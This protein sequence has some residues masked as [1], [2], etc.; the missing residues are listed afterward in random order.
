MTWNRLLYIQRV[1]KLLVTRLNFNSRNK[2]GI[3]IAN[4]HHYFCSMILAYL[5]A[6]GQ[7]CHQTQLKKNHKDFEHCRYI[8]CCCLIVRKNGLD[9]FRIYH[10]F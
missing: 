5:K 3:L 1:V 9:L 10:V 4:K 2:S 6:S 8:M 7:L